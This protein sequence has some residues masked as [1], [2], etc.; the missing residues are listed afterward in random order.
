M[1]RRFISTK[2]T[3]NILLLK[4]NEVLKANL[5]YQNDSVAASIRDS[6]AM[7]YSTVVSK[8]DD[9]IMK[10]L[11]TQSIADELKQYP[12]KVFDEDRMGN[13]MKLDSSG[14]IFQVA[15]MQMEEFVK[16]YTA[17]AF[18]DELR[19]Y[20]D[21][22]LKG[23][24]LNLWFELSQ[25]NSEQDKNKVLFSTTYITDDIEG[26]FRRSF[27]TGE[28]KFIYSRSDITKDDVYQMATDFGKVNAA[29]I[30][31][32]FLN[33]YVHTHYKG[34]KKLPYLHY[35]LLK[36]RLRQAGLNRFIFM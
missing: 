5:A 18:Y 36:K 7:V 19:F 28:V 32:Y 30:F 22:E 2:D 10:E 27:L 12:C 26:V 6:L 17:D 16:P 24:N 11:L 1:A 31:D 23:V 14:V 3:L 9:K 21:F 34:K 15:Q 8:A 4:P 35:D 13:F 33:Q 29:Y 20:Q 25:L